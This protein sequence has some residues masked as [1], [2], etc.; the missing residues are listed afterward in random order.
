ME[1]KK[2]PNENQPNGGPGPVDPPWPVNARAG[3]DRWTHWPWSYKTAPA[4]I[5]DLI[6]RPVRV[7][8]VGDAVTQDVVPGRVT[9]MVG[10]DGRI[11]DILVDASLPDK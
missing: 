8:K 7:V 4:L 10:T 11:D 1:T 3:D 6:G 9:V 2:M 5:K